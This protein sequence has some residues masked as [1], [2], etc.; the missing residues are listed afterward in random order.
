MDFATASKI[1]VENSNLAKEYSEF[2]GK[3]QIMY[4]MTEENPTYAEAIANDSN[5]SSQVRYLA[6]KVLIQHNSLKD[7]AES[8]MITINRGESTPTRKASYLKRRSY[9][10]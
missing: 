1:I 6:C 7:D 10:E 3:L 9:C 8:V 4:T 2:H 5:C